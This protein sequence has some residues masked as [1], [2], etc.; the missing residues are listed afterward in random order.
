MKISVITPTYN[1]A[2]TLGK[3]LDSLIKQEVHPFEHII[4]DGKSSDETVQI[5]ERYKQSAPFNVIIVSEKD[6]GIYDA[7]NKGIKLANGDVLGI[8]NS[9]D[10]Y[11]PNALKDI[12]ISYSNNGSGVYYGYQ[13]YILDEKEFYIERSHIDFIGQKMI[14]HPT[15]FITNDIYQRFGSFDLKY[16]YSADLEMLFRFKS[17]N[18]SFFL[19]DTIISNF[20]I[21]GASSSVDAA[22][23]TLRL[24]LHFGYISRNQYFFKLLKLKVLKIF[25]K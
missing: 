11:E 15:C 6:N 22:F 8:V 12:Q 21:G 18:V 2:K 7:M 16:K 23:E 1:S 4:I 14:Q 10:W 5:L 25:K 20:R 13:R 24:K 3:T 17:N 9:D 19:L